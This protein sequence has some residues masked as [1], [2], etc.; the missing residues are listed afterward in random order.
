MRDIDE[1]WVSYNSYI[2]N[3]MRNTF[4]VALAVDGSKSFIFFIYNQLEW[5][6]DPINIGFRDSNGSRSFMLA[7]TLSGDEV[8]QLRLSETSNVGVPG[9]YLYQVDG[10]IV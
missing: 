4:Q 9:L 5:T 1:C 10:E 7:E 6:R 3:L 2:Q 8:R